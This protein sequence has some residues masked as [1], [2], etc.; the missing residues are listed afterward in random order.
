M[1]PVPGMRASQAL[2][3][4]PPPGHFLFSAELG[5]DRGDFC[6]QRAVRED[7]GTK[8]R[9]E[10]PPGSG[11]RSMMALAVAQGPVL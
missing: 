5:S 2:W 7:P 10:E 8:A 6:K 4:W 9:V 1:P 3:V 11:A